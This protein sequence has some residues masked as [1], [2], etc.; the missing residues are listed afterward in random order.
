MGT[1]KLRWALFSSDE[2]G[3]F[4]AEMVA[5][6]WLMATFKHVMFVV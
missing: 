6:K 5:F 4:Q 3:A 1:F 2:I